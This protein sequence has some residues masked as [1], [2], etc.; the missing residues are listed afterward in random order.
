VTSRDSRLDG[1]RD[2]MA[3]VI[4]AEEEQ[5]LAE[6]RSALLRARPPALRP[7]QGDEAFR[8]HKLLA[9]AVHRASRLDAR[10]SEIGDRRLGAI[11]E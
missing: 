8:Q 10:G 5:A 2:P 11:R 4:T 3:P 7:D 9:S 6:L 1:Y